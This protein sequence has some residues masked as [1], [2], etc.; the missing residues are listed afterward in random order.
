MN[1][2]PVVHPD[3]LIALL[4][5]HGIW[6][7]HRV[8]I[9]LSQTHGSLN[10]SI[11]SPGFGDGGVKLVGIL[12][13]YTAG[14]SVTASAHAMRRALAGVTAVLRAVRRLLQTSSLQQST[15]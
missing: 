8:A 3:V 5:E 6:G 2:P 7:Y 9:S 15:V 13:A 11:P 14:A 4:R 1:L 10:C 12:S